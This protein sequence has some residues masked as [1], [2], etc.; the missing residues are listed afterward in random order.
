MKIKVNVLDRINLLSLIP[1]KG[2]FASMNSYIEA[3]KNILLQE[4]EVKEFEYKAE[5][6]QAMWN[7][8]G[9]EDKEIEIGEIAFEAIKKGLKDLNDKKE[10][11]VQM[12]PT[13]EKLTK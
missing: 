4:D 1:E 13:Y 10:I 12:M 7:A 2:D 11:T 9:R 3:R 8:K 5:G 6:N